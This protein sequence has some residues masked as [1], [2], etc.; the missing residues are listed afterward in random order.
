MPPTYIP[1]DSERDN[2]KADSHWEQ[3]DRPRPLLTTTGRDS[4]MWPKS[5]GASSDTIDEVSFYSP[6]IKYENSS[7]R[8]RASAP[9]VIQKKKPNK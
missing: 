2:V 7:L 4:G 6:D 9:K 8:H 3:K 1:D 5:V